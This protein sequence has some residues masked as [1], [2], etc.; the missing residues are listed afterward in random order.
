[1]DNRQ[2][3][4]TKTTPFI[5]SLGALSLFVYIM[6]RVLPGMLPFPLVDR[7]IDAA[8]IMDQAG[9]AVR[10]CRLAAGVPLNTADD[11]NGTGFIGLDFSSI[12]TSLGSLP[13]KRTSAN[14]NFAALLVYLLDKAGVEKGDCVAVGA[15]SSFPALIVA[16]LSAC[17][18]LGARPLLICSLGASQWGANHPEFHWLKMWECLKEK[19]IFFAEPVA[20]SLGGDRDMGQ[21]MDPGGRARLLSALEGRR[22]RMISDPDLSRNISKRMGLLR[23]EA[24]EG[25]IKAFIN[26]GGSWA[27]LGTDESVLKITPGLNLPRDIPLPERRGMIQEMAARGVP[28]IHCLFIRGLAREFGLPWDPSPLPEPGAGGVFRMAREERPAFTFLVLIYIL[29]VVL[30]TLIWRRPRL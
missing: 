22:L 1:M 15:S 4:K 9:E 11:I 26:I 6:A 23:Q 21:D 18:A 8:R 28:V 27:N 12:T 17:R 7:M 25:A 2:V 30:M 10:G 29:A 13:A 16:S 5:F 19:G 3:I 14:P 20:W 24:G